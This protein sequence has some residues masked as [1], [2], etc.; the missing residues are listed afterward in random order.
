[1]RDEPGDPHDPSSEAFPHVYGPIPVSAVTRV[2]P[3]RID[4]GRVVV[5]SSPGVEA[6]DW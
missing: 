4:R 3:A 5:D 6:P 1:M 2:L